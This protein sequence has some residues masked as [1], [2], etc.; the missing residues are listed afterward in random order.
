MHRGNYIHA[1]LGHI[2]REKKEDSLEWHNQQHSE[3]K[4][5]SIRNIPME[6]TGDFFF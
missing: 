6:C 5:V 1:T 4:N 2:T 3:H